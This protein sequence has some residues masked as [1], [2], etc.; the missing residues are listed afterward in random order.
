MNP[1]AQSQNSDSKDSRDNKPAQMK[2]L[3][4][5]VPN[6]PSS[7]SSEEENKEI[8]QEIHRSHIVQTIQSLQYIQHVSRS[9]PEAIK[10]RAIYLPKTTKQ[11]T[12]IFD[13]DE[14]LVHCIEDI[15]NN[16]HDLPITV[17]FPGGDTVQA[18]I[19]VRPYSYQ[20]L[21]NASEQYQVIIFTASHQAYADVVI[22]SLERE[23]RKERY[24]TDSEQKYFA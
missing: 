19:N 15:Q 18:G 20:C 1:D 16:P 12:I 22:D 21:K 23:F 3:V 2:D 4:T 5:S 17:C 14:T 11:K 10:Q 13:L 9:T 7:G 8:Y 6:Q 24:L